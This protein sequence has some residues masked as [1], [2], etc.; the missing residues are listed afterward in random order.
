MSSTCTFGGF[1]SQQVWVPSGQTL[2]PR[3]VLWWWNLTEWAQLLPVWTHPQ[4]VKLMMI[5]GTIKETSFRLCTS[6]CPLPG[7]TDMLQV[8]FVQINIVKSI[9][10]IYSDGPPRY[11][12][13]IIFHAFYLTLAVLHDHHLMQNN[14][15][16][17]FIAWE[18]A[19]LMLT[20][21]TRSE[22]RGGGSTRQEAQE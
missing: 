10:L 16:H 2:M 8:P 15:K 6:A 14:R 13:H 1:Y 9:N 17:T 18:K 21:E 5:R 11:L 19:F 3:D 7:Q 12:I 4:S 20:L 22:G